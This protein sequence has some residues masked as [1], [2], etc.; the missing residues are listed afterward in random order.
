M[1]AGGAGAP[2]RGRRLVPLLVA[3]PAPAVLSA[4]IK[5]AGLALAIA[6]R[7]G[8]LV[9]DRA[10]QAVAVSFGIALTR[11]LAGLGEVPPE[12]AARAVRVGRGRSYSVGAPHAGTFRTVLLLI[13]AIVS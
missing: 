10:E 13:A 3:L 9:T 2:D 8:H 4:S 7:G 1:R 5:H 11:R 12:V 6:Q